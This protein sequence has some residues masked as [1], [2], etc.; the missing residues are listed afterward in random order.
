MAV[1][2]LCNC[3]QRCR[4]TLLALRR[5]R[6]RTLLLSAQPLADTR[7]ESPPFLCRCQYHQPPPF[8][9]PS[10]AGKGWTWQAAGLS[11]CVRSATSQYALVTLCRPAAGQTCPCTLYV[12]PRTNIVVATPRKKTRRPYKTE[13]SATART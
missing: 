13:R 2:T 1:H 10:A 9:S 12:A 8:S 11:I 4:L 5:S 3:L 7:C 6:L